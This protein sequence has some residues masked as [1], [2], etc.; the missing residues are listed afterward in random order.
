VARGHTRAQKKTH[1][2]RLARA[3]RADDDGDG[4]R[5]YQVEQ[6]VP[7]VM[8][9]SGLN[10]KMDGKIMEKAVFFFFLL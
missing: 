8:K 2:C 5:F 6:G 4:V 10:E 3:G 1:H 7:V 9:C